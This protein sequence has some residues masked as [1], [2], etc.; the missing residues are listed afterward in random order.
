MEGT[1]KNGKN[2]IHQYV[3]RVGEFMCWVRE[4][5]DGAAPAFPLPVLSAT[6]VQSEIEAAVWK[7]VFHS[8]SK[9]TVTL[10]DFK[11]GL[12]SR[13]SPLRYKVHK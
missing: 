7:C 11:P 6:P 12:G 9:I 5:G 10:T 1:N 3:C 4:V 13:D 2:K 8:A